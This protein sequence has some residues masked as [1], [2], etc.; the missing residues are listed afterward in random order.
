MAG[1]LLREGTGRQHASILVDDGQRD[2]DGSSGHS[3]MSAD[4]VQ[5]IQGFKIGVVR[6]RSRVYSRLL[7]D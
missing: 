7:S 6:M 2:Q 5:D 1:A 3:R 4:K